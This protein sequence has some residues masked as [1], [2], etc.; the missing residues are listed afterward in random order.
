MPDYEI[1]TGAAGNTDWNND[2]NWR[3]ADGNTTTEEDDFNGDELYRGNG[4]TTNSNS[5]L[6]K[7]TTNYDNYRTAKDRVFR[8]G[9]APLYCTH[10]LMSRDEWGNAPVLY[11][12]LDGNAALVKKPFPNLRDEDNWDNEGS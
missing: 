3:R 1:W 2:Q 9:F 6:N 10:V 4:A 12:A 7:Y 5:P 11:D 8:R